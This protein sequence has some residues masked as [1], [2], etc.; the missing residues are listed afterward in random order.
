MFFSR[1]ILAVSC[2]ET[3]CEQQ[4]ADAYYRSGIQ[5]LSQ[6]TKTWRQQLTGRVLRQSRRR[7]A[8]LNRRQT[9]TWTSNDVGP[10]ILSEDVYRNGRYFERSKMNSRQQPSMAKSR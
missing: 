7:P 2:E 6:M 10:T 1:K 9:R 8:N 3:V 5:C 4:R